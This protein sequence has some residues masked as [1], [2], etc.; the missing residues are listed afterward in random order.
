[1]KRSLS[2]ALCA[3]LILIVAAPAFAA[4]HQISYDKALATA[5]ERDALV[6][7]D[8]FT[9]WCV[10]CKQFDK[11][12]ADPASGIATALEDVVFTS[13]DA[14]KG[15]GIALAE[16]YGVTGFPTYVVVNT[17]GELIESWA[18]YG[19]PDHFLGAFEVA[20][21]DPTTFEQ[22]KARYAAEPTAA[23]AQALAR[24]SSATGD[25]AG[26]MEYMLA[27]ESLDQDLDLGSELLESAYRRVRSDDAYAL[28]DYLA[29]ARE[30]VIEGEADAATTVLTTYF[31]DQ[32]TKDETG[33]ETVRP[34]LAKSRAAIA[35][36][37]EVSAGLAN[38]VE[39]RALILV[40]GDL[41]A[42]V[43]K[44]RG[45][46]AEGW[47]EDA[48]QLNAFA[49]WCFENNVNLVEAQQLALEGIE[50]AA[51]GKERAMILDT[52]AELCNALGNC[53]QAIELT[54]KAIES[55]P[56]NEYYGEQLARFEEILAAA[57]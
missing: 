46:M 57:E 23:S 40:D 41:D 29:L 43:E 5:K 8:F 39:L 6:V 20:L 11:A 17:D 16:K 32:L 55:D 44:K 28:D 30:R 1:M 54:R 45:M 4:D 12:L 19:G 36:G 52:A 3:A 27:A 50:L 24:V 38:A 49:W 42:A 10:Y 34:F 22:K 21:A 13:I 48:S 2:A 35:S 7:I 51:P 33:H 47:R 15:E 56:D 14:E 37:A 25:Y 18:G 26:A 53:G 31:V 9:D